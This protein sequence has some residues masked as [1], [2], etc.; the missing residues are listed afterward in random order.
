M[1]VSILF[2]L[3]VVN[4]IYKD[5][6]NSNPNEANTQLARFLENVLP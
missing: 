1:S 6:L 3:G 5:N 4:A 2:Y